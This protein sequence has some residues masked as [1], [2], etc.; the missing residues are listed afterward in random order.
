MIPIAD[1]TNTEG[2]SIIDLDN[3]HM[4]ER[5]RTLKCRRNQLSPIYRLPV[6]ILCNIFKFSLTESQTRTPESWINFSQVS[7]H[8]RSSALNAPEL[9]T[10][11]LFNYPRWAKKM[12]IRSKM[13]RLTIRT[14]PSPEVLSPKTI[15]TIR[16]CLYEMSRVEEIQLTTIPRFIMEQ[17]FQDLP[18]SAPHLHTLRIIYFLEPAF[19]IHEDFLHDT[20]RLQC[21]EL[22]GCNI[23]WDCWLLTGL[24]YLT[25]AVSL[26][27]NSSIIQV[28]KPYNECLH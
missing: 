22:I 11:I 27:E 23:S 2:G 14:Y 16:S 20:E 26:K 17:I 24:T 1:D 5:I 28:C 25:L 4:E 13:A 6:E 18:K 10:N 19:S 21:V 3:T 12:L 7:Q 9:W 8:W 15:E